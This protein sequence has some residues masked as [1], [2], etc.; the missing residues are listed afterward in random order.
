MDYW[1]AASFFS[2]IRFRDNYVKISSI[3]HMNH[4]FGIKI[5]YKDVKCVDYDGKTCIIQYKNKKFKFISSYEAYNLLAKVL[6]SYI[7]E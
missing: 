3:Y 4:P 5:Y 2:D 6:Y 7:K 1:L